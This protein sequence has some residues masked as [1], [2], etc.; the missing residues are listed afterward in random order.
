VDKCFVCGTVN[1]NFSIILDHIKEENF[2][3]FRKWSDANKK[4]LLCTLE[5]VVRTF[6]IVRKARRLLEH[7]NN[8]MFCVVEGRLFTHIKKWSFD[9]RVAGSV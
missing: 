5:D 6:G 1:H 7:I 3:E 4:P 8:I 9:K 2:N